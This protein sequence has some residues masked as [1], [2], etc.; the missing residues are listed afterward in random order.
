[1]IFHAVPYISRIKYCRIRPF[2]G[3]CEQDN[4][5]SGAMKYSEFVEQPR[6]Y[7]LLKKDAALRCYFSRSNVTTKCRQGRHLVPSAEVCMDIE[8]PSSPKCK[9]RATTNGN[10]RAS[11]TKEMESV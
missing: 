7:Q 9:F 11:L 1:M 5:H 8:D 3:S 10:K 2:V 4:G 6:D